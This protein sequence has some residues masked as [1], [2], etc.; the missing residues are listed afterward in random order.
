M[1][2]AHLKANL[3]K[4]T[5]AASTLNMLAGQFADLTQVTADGSAAGNA[6]LASALS[7]FAN[8]W[9]DKRTQFISQMK[10]LATDASNA[11]KAYEATDSKLAAALKPGGTTAKPRP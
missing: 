9:S 8:G 1:P 5:Q 7:N 6:A 11:V 2:S 3:T 4:I 10:G